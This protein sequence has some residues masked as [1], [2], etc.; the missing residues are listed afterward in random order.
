MEE[1]SEILEESLYI[2][3]SRREKL[4]QV[5]DSRI[6]TLQEMIIGF[7]QQTI[8]DGMKPFE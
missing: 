2:D 7:T 5:L 3:D 1:C 6:E 4:C 8:N